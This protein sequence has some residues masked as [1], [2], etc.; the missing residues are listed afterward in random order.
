[1]KYWALWLGVW[2]GVRKSGGRDMDVE[3]LEREVLERLEEEL[4]NH[5]KFYLKRKN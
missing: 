3:A 1:M 5:L 4:D 2:Y